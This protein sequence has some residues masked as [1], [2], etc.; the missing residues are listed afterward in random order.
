MAI[1]FDDTT[2]AGTLQ[3]LQGKVMELAVSAQAT[4]EKQHTANGEHKDITA[5][6]LTGRNGQPVV[7][8][9]GV[10][11][12]G[13]PQLYIPPAVITPDPLTADT[14]NWAPP[15]IA[16]AQVVEIRATASVRLTGIAVTGK[17]RSQRR[18]LRLVNLSTVNLTLPSN[19]PDSAPEHRFAFGGVDFLLM[20]GTH[21]DLYYEPAGVRW[22]GVP[23]SSGSGG[24]GGA[25]DPHAPT[26]AAGGSDAVSVT[27]LAG[28]PG[29]TGTFLRSDATFAAGV[30]GPAGPVGPEGPEGPQG[31]PGPTGAT[32]AQGIQGVPGVDGADG[33]TGLQGDPGPPGPQGVKGDTGA[34]GAT[35]ATGPE[36]PQGVKGD[37]GL[38]GLPGVP[39]ATGPEGPQGP[40]GIQG[41]P[42]TPGATGA[43]GDKGDPG[44]TGAQGIQGP[45]GPEGPEGDP[46]PQGIQG[47]IGP[48][49]PKGDPGDPAALV[50]HHVTHE[51][52]GTDVLANNAW[53]NTA[54]V[55]TAPQTVPDG[56]AVQGN[57]SL[58]QFLS[59]GATANAKVWRMLNYGTGPLFI[60]ALTDDGATSQ[61]YI[62]I[63]RGSALQA[64]GGLLGTP[65]NASQLTTGTVP[66][67]RLGPN[68][69]LKN[70]PQTVTSGLT[71]RASGAGDNAARV[72]FQDDV[73]SSPGS[74]RWQIYGYQNNL[75]HV[76]LDDTETVVHATHTMGRDGRFFTDRVDLAK[77]QVRFQPG[78]PS[79]DVNVLDSYQEGEWT[80]YL[81]STN[82]SSGITYS[83]QLG[84]YI[85]IGQTVWVSF[86]LPLTSAGTMTGELLLQ[87][88]PFRAKPWPMASN[89]GT[90]I[91]N[92]PIEYHQI[93]GSIN[94]DAWNVQLLIHGMGTGYF[95]P[96][97]PAWIA[98]STRF[99]GTFIY[100]TRD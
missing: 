3:S 42:G 57:N 39:G 96:L 46:G 18:D 11:W 99:Q 7:I 33:A 55:F 67:A 8:R 59:T 52:G 49:G 43:K 73:S 58:L 32:G 29:G 5:G 87:G 100:R 15:G 68:V 84:H 60:E 92:L 70:V 71:V 51:P 21:V 80:P 26:H 9:S 65:L 88:L 47:P 19:S 91:A 90:V 16:T 1:L 14:H 12:A 31:D 61:G 81:D 44:A 24:G 35:G 85:K 62:E 25:P 63:T 10:V 22:H 97:Q 95:Q 20:A 78:F 37:T 98:N 40:Q 45:I 75:S 2:D 27:A 54:N 94:A 41:I 36:G 28:Y 82:G 66:D 6:S 48:E 72:K 79:T 17:L 89:I 77:G 30:A 13:G 4:I 34:P 93:V 83:H 64:L 86:D 69:Y 23:S 56:T 53:T 38:Q 74:T 50:A 76:A